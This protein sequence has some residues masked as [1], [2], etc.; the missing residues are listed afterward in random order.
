MSKIMQLVKKLIV[1]GVA[2]KTA[3]LFLK[4]IIKKTKW[5]NKVFI[6]GGYVRDE[7]MGKDPKDIDIVI[8][9]PNGGIEFAEWFTKKIGNYKESSNPVIYP[10]YGTAKFTLKGVTF[11]G[12]D[13]SHIDIEAVMPRSEK[14]TS[15]SR[16]PEVE[17]SDM[18]GDA[19]RRD[20][21]INSLFKNVSTGKILDLTGTG[22]KDLNSKILRTPIDADSTF[23]DDPL[24]MLRVVRF[25]AKTGFNVPFSLLKS[26]KKNAFRLEIISAERIQDELNKMLVTSKPS[27]A[28]KMLKITGL[29]PFISQDLQNAVGMKQNSHHT[30]DVFGHTLDV[31][32]KTEPKLINRLMALFHDIGKTVTKSVTPT[33]VH[34]YGHEDAGVDI[35]RNVMKKLKYP[36]ATIDA[37]CLGVKHHMKLKHGGDDS[38]QMS[39]KTLRKFTMEVGDKLETILD[40]IHADNIA[41]ASESSMPNQIT[42]IKKR[43]ETLNS[44]IESSKIELPLNGHDLIRMGIKPG[45][46]IKHLLE[47]VLDAWYENPDITKQEAIDLI[48]KKINS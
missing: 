2:E 4:T 39:D 41:H 6:A 45:P 17:L 42:N 24:R 26:I 22:K 47:L 7:L 44:S 48:N 28:L 46:Q 31:V 43:L 40:V 12:V 19:K 9:A 11:K 20:L 8:N 36:T 18:E 37:V 25:Y 14:Y 1:E 13:L 29:L 23:S 5:E 16:K 27:E 32:S 15:T 3:E 35:A 30:K 34:F 33:G 10:T 21:T 38:I